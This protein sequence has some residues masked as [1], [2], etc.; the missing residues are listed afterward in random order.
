M[1]RKGGRETTGFPPP[2][3]KDLLHLG[4]AERRDHPD[5][6][7]RNALPNQP[8]QALEELLLLFEDHRPGH[9]R[10]SLISE[11]DSTG[12]FFTKSR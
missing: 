8:P 11:M 7:P 6:L 12:R 1:M 9:Q 10:C 5:L 2:A 3:G 4:D